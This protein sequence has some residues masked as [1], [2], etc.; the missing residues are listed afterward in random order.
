MRFNR[1]ADPDRLPPALWILVG[2]MALT[3]LVL[4]LSDRGLLP[5]DLRMLALLHGAFWTPLLDGTA[6][7][8]F[9]G[10]AV[11]MFVTHAFL[12]GGFFHLAMNGVILLALGKMVAER[13]GAG[14]MLLLFFA[15]AIGGGAVFW[16]LSQGGAPMIGAS[17]AVF[18][19]LGLWQYWE[20]MAR[21]RRGL[22][23][24][25]VIATVGG[26]A[27]LNLVLAFMLQGALAW[28]AHLGGF[29]V[30]VALGPLMTRFA[31]VS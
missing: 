14:G 17:G 5:G 19:F 11:T 28:Q 8:V 21:H 27:V 16:L 22:P 15:S 24:Q 6:W 1:P 31:K 12:H 25:P 23:L 10:Q 20:G 13:A 2:A 26:L 29:L 9:S 7:P 3:E 30:G 18:G 4:A